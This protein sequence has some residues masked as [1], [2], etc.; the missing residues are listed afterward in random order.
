MALTWLRLGDPQQA[1]GF[2]T[3]TLKAAQTVRDERTVAMVSQVEGQVSLCLGEWEAAR[4]PFRR[5]VE[6]F[7]A[8]P[9]RLPVAPALVLLGRA[10]LAQEEK[11]AAADCFRDALALASQSELGGTIHWPIHSFVE[12]P[13]VAEALSGLEEIY[14]DR[15]AF[16]ALC[17]RFRSQ[18]ADRPFVQWTLEPA[19]PQRDCVSR[20]DCVPHVPRGPRIAY[21]GWDTD[22]AHDL[23]SEIQMGKWSWH[24]P[25]GDC[26]YTTRDGLKIRAANGRNLLNVNLSAPRLLRPASGDWVA[27]TQCVPVSGQAPAIGG[28]VLWVAKENYLRLD[29]GA[30]GERDVYFGGCLENRDVLIGRGRLPPGNNSGRV[31]LQL[32]R[33]AEQVRAFCSTDG[34]CWFTAGQV[35]FPVEDP[36]QVGVFAIGSIDRTVYHGAYPDG[37][38]I[39]FESFRLWEA[40]T[41]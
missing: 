40:M 24:D 32:E 33:V 4:D 39:R 15:E 3:R 12:N 13:L 8:I 10:Q 5:A 19:Q 27:Q 7:R 29:R 17:R 28:L 35:T 37:T 30:I 6:L 34:E 11:E 1:R 23:E 21:S 22:H 2:A 31:F 25:F 26:A 14:Q 9:L 16:R 41:G 18:A 36:V 20:R 38:A